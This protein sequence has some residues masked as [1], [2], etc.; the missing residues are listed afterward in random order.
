MI[1]V[2]ISEEMSLAA[3]ASALQEISIVNRHE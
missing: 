1:L 3:S 2:P